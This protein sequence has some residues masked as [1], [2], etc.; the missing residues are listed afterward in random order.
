MKKYFFLAFCA[1][2]IASPVA[3]SCAVLN[4][5]NSTTLIKP[6]QTF[7]LGEGEHPSYSVALTNVGTTLLIV[8]TT[9]R[10]GTTTPVANLKPNDKGS[11]KI[12]ANTAA[13]IKND[14]K[15]QGTVKI[16]AQG[17]V[18]FSNLSMGYDK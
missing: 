15:V 10:S 12:P 2:A 8:T 16:R 4:T 11:Y 14:G 6:Q 5:I 3:Q 9:D 7:I 17:A 13:K 1:A 18:S